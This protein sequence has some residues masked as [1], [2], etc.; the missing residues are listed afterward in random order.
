MCWN[1]IH[2][3]Y[4]IS[5]S[6]Y[7]SQY[8]H[9][10]RQ[11]QLKD[12]TEWNRAG[13]GYLL[14]G[15][16]TILSLRQSSST[17]VEKCGYCWS[18]RLTC[19][20]NVRL[21]IQVWQTS[22]LWKHTHPKKASTHHELMMVSYVDFTIKEKKQLLIYFSRVLYRQL[23]KNPLRLCGNSSQKESGKTADTLSQHK[24]CSPRKI[25]IQ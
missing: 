22:R 20:T 16:R 17:V 15:W 12:G 24:M 13:V 2:K 14:E 8:N 5:N 11:L 21:E 9:R 18:C 23:E 1:L 7:S 3:L 25:I 6:S 4:R 19:S 10:F